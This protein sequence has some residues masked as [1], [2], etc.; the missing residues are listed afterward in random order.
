MNWSSR[1]F[2][3]SS[4]CTWPTSLLLLLPSV[5]P[6]VSRSVVSVERSLT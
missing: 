3:V 4:I 6:D 2:A 5:M 1:L